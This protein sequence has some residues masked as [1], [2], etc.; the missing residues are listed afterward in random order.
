MKSFTRNTFISSLEISQTAF[1]CYL[2]ILS[3]RITEKQ[4]FFKQQI[5]Y[6]KV[7]IQFVFYLFHR[8]LLR[9]I[10]LHPKMHSP[11]KKHWNGSLHWIQ[12]TC[13]LMLGI[14]DRFHDKERMK[15]WRLMATFLY[16]I[17]SRNLAT[18]FSRAKQKRHRLFISCLVSAWR[19]RFL[20]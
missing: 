10:H 9:L 5:Y 8:N 3:Q 20:K 4:N 7:L 13:V 17:V 2:F 6:E 14:M 16:V 18:M 11:S 19:S 15:S 1:G 12:E